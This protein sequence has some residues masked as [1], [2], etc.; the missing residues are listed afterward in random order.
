M[1][2]AGFVAQRW[3]GLA[4][5]QRAA[6][7]AKG[8]R[9]GAVTVRPMHCDSSPRYSN[10]KKPCCRPETRRK[11]AAK[12]LS[13]EGNDLKVAIRE[14]SAEDMRPIKA[15]SRIVGLSKVRASDYFNMNQ[16][17]SH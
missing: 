7:D 3:L 13:P 8:D 12:V 1:K 17:L 5:G 11:L 16:Y 9:G 10:R 15:G 14:G 6:L 2:V 4:E